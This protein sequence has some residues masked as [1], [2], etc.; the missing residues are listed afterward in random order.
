MAKSKGVVFNIKN[1]K[2]SVYDHDTETYGMPKD[3]AYADSLALDSTYAETVGY[4]DGKK[5]VV[6]PTDHGFTGQLVVTAIENQYE[7]DMGRKMQLATGLA[8]TTQK[9][10]VKH[11]IYF[12]LEKV[13]DDGSGTEVMKIWLYNCITGAAGET[14]NQN[15]DSP[16]INTYSY[17]LSVMG[18]TILQNGSTD[19]YVDEFGVTAIATKN[20]VVPGDAN[21]ATFGES[22]PAPEAPAA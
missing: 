18:D 6:I 12:E 15:G 3:L 17:P 4:G 8:T 7:L 16:T 21:Y 1:L 13:Q 2:Y 11:A 14:Y 22:V 10:S 5:N 20:S 9:Q 19:P